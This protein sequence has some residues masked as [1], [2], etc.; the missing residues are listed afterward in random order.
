MQVRDIEIGEI[1]E[2]RSGHLFFARELSFLGERASDWPV[3]K[4][5]FPHGQCAALGLTP[6]SPESPLTL[7]GHGGSPISVSFSS[8]LSHRLDLLS[9]QGSAA[10]GLLPFL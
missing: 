4:V 8:S 2:Y 7:L 1:P 10:S 6:P 5:S 3:F 9:L